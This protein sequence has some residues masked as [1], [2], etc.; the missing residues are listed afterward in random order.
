M[1]KATPTEGDDMLNKIVDLSLRY[2]LLVLVG[3]GL[4]VFLGVRAFLA[5]PVDA[6]PDVTPNQVNVYTESPGLAAEDVEKLL[7]SPIET[8]MAGLPGVEQLRSVSLFRSGMIFWVC[9]V[10][11]RILANLMTPI[12]LKER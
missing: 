12:S 11:R 6:F 9:S 7:T 10:L 1:A 4:V 5:V 2:K 3:F 8:A